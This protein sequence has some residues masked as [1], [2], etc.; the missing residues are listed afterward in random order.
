MVVAIVGAMCCTLQQA[1]PQ[2][3]LWPWQNFLLNAC[4][5]QALRFHLKQSLTAEGVE[6]VFRVDK[7]CE[8]HQRP[9]PES[10]CHSLEFCLRE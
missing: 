3:L 1:L 9:G 6:R 7:L 10:C 5:Q 8:V 2:H 4:Y